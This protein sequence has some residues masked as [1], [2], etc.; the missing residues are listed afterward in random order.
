M[1]HPS[2]SQSFCMMPR[3][4]VEQEN[5]GLL[6]SKVADHVLPN[7]SDK[8]CWSLEGSQEFSLKSSRI[9]IDN[10]ILPKAEVPTRSLR[11]VPIK[12][13]V[14]AWRVCL[15][16]LPTRANL[17]LR[18]MDIPSIAWDEDG[19]KGLM[20]IE[21]EIGGH[22]IHRMYVDGGSAS[23]ILYEHC[24][25][26]LWDAKHFAS[27]WM[28]FVVVKSQS[29]YNGIIGRP[30]V[31]KI[32]AVP[33]TAHRML[34]F[35]VPGGILTLRSIR[36]IPLKCTMVSGLKTQPFDIIQAAEERIKVAIHP[37]YPEQKIAIGFTLTKK[38][39]KALCDL[40][41]RNLD[42]FR[43]KPV[44]MTGVPRHLAK[45]R[46]NVRDGCSPVRQ[47]K[48]SQAL[49]RNKTIEDE[50]GAEIW[51]TTFVVNDNDLR[52][53]K[54]SDEKKKGLFPAHPRPSCET[55]WEALR[56]KLGQSRVR[57]SPPRILRQVLS[58]IVTNNSLKSSPRK[59][60]AGKAKGSKSPSQLRRMF[61]K[62]LKNS[63]GFTTLR[64]QNTKRKRG[65][66]KGTT[67]RPLP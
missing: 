58:S 29:P 8:L 15:D 23:E 33:S 44:D 16:K 59:S 57:R 11:V 67:V 52:Q 45:H 46:L 2:L 18:G 36:I 34:K 31:R 25:N 32:Q 6:C 28:N 42:I 49:E 54:Q 66:P 20:I 60:A 7:I 30:G 56:K 10:T 4:G 17:S 50:G 1:G 63:R 62:K 65:A 61:R 24:F 43:W 47:R 3:G 39:R 13:N 19:T 27:T 21:A 9:L 40:L 26:R 41:R 37:E 64:V 55:Q 35:S 12:V 14:Y 53:R 38:G 51:W 48:R 5:Y 22:F